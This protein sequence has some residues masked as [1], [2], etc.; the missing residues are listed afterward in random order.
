MRKLLLILVIII[1][2][3]NAQSTNEAENQINQE[4]KKSG[5]VQVLLIGTS[6]WD[7]Y[8]KADLDVAQAD[9]IDIL[10]NQYQSEL[11][12]IIAK[13]VEF[14]PT[15]VFVERTIAYQP[16]LDSIYNLYKTSDWGKKSRNEIV[17]L[18]FKVAKKLDHNKV[19]GI[20]YRETSFPYDSLM[21][22]MKVSKQENLISEFENDIKNFEKEYNE[23]VYNKTPLKDI[24]YYLNDKERRKFDLGWYLNKATQAGGV[25]DHVGAFLGSEWVKRNIYSYGI[26]Q[27]YTDSDDERIMVLM[28][29]SHIAVFENLIAYNPGWEAVEL[30]DIMK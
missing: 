14:N 10:S 3:C 27:K 29:A 17:Q 25:E 19:Y 13:I 7:N 21:K 4:N 9:E 18:G 5:K 8:Q 28:G 11:T 30:K 16:K 2:S 1:T 12:E 23:L 22:I 26:M 20:D 6:H 15:K 24:L